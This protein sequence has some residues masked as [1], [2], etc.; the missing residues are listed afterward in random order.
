MP[1]AVRLAGRSVTTRANFERSN[2]PSDSD[3]HPS[4]IGPPAGGRNVAPTAADRGPARARLHLRRHRR[5]P[6][7][8]SVEL[9]HAAVRTIVEERIEVDELEARVVESVDQHAER[10]LAGEELRG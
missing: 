6:R 1:I 3:R 5:T 9:E 10:R 8:Q 4:P 2:H 7:E